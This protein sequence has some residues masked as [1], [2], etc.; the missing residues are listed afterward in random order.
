M[1]I[2][3]TEK[4]VDLENIISGLD[5]D[6]YG[7]KIMLPKT[8]AFLVLINAISCGA[9]NILK[10][11]MLSLGGDVALPRG[12][13][14]GRLKKT[15]CLLMGN[16]AQ[17]NCLKDKLKIQPFGL[18]SLSRNL[19]ECLSNYQKDNF[20]VKVSKYTLNLGR[21]AYIMGIVN[22]TGDSFSGDGLYRYAQ[23]GLNPCDKMDFVSSMVEDGADIIDVGGQ[24]S[25]PG[26]RPIS[27]KEESSRTVPLIKLLAKKIKVPISIDTYR[28]EVARAALDSGAVIINDING[29][30]DPQMRKVAARYKAAVVIMHMQGRPLNMPIHPQ[31]K[32]LMGEII[33]YL[34]NS[35]NLALESGVDKEKIIVDPGIGFGKTV[36]HNLQII[37]RLK[38]LKCIGRPILVGP[39]RKSFIGKVL[40]VKPNERLSGTITAAVLSFKNGANILRV[41]DVKQVAQALKVSQAILAN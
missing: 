2:L 30:R 4:D 5:V 13:L 37:S 15:D 41:H 20:V 12:V 19:S 1:R 21:R 23:G 11:E 17:L 35:I 16:L 7:L 39:S 9:A 36:A 22:A 34:N 26:A 40:N 3:A 25:R 6:P 18:K 27:L 28:P 14:T 24:S 31:Y 10:Q 29:L 38:E 32:S 33:S 8:K